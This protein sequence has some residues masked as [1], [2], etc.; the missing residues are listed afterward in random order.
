M[1][2]FYRIRPGVQMVNTRTTVLAYETKPRWEKQNNF[3]SDDLIGHRVEYLSIHRTPQWNNIIRYAHIPNEQ[4]QFP[5]NSKWQS[6]TIKK[7][8]LTVKT[9]PTTSWNTLE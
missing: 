6:S 1:V 9:K 2:A 4:P 8:K 5:Y 7:Q 3:I